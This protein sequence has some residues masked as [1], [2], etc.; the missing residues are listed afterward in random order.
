LKSLKGTL[1]NFDKRRRGSLALL[2]NKENESPENGR[3]RSGR[4]GKGFSWETGSF[5][6]PSGKKEEST[7]G[8]KKNQG[9]DLN[10]KRGIPLK[11]GKRMTNVE[12]NEKE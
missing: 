3:G 2:T 11:L 7:G 1:V 9:T 10:A 6:R 5:Q 4:E 12:S 8:K